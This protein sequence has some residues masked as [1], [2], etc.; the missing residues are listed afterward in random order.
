MDLCLLYFLI[1]ALIKE[2][3]E[4]I[5]RFLP[6]L[7]NN[8]NGSLRQI[9]GR[10]DR[11]PVLILTT[12]GKNFSRFRRLQN[13]IRSYTEFRVFFSGSNHPLQIVQQRLG[14]APLS[15]HINFPVTER[16]FI[17]HRTDEARWICG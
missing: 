16:A 17:N 6:K 12:V 14:V 9:M 13:A 1:W 2:V 15:L 7:D 10:N 3:N 8:F 4:V 5:K 11:I